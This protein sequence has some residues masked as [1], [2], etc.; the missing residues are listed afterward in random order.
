MWADR[1]GCKFP[2]SK[3]GTLP[4]NYHGYHPA[5]PPLEDIDYV[6]QVDLHPRLHPW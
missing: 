3:R 6:L 4:S 5:E 2:F 1:L